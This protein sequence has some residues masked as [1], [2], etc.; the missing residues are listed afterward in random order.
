V[1][2]LA[3]REAAAAAEDPAVRAVLS[4]IAADEERHAELAW[5]TVAW[6]LG[7][8]GRDVARALAAALEAL[9]AEPDARE[10]AEGSSL[11]A[12]GVL[13]A[14]SRR[15]IRRRALAEVVLPCAE[16]LLVAANPAPEARVSV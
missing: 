11:A 5:R 8:G 3:L 1:A 14:A 6:A 7:A 16:A 10:P 15:E 12:F 9:R 4:R 13:D 2:A